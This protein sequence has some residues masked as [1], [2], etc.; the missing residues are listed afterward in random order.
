MITVRDRAGTTVAE[1]ATDARGTSTFPLAPGEYEVTGA[2][3]PRAHITPNPQ[4]V[5]IGAATTVTL[6]LRY[7]SAFQ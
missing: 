2:P 1:R 6:R 3:D 7:A 4:R 5:T